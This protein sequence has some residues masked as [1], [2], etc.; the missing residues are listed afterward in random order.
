MTI[1]TVLLAFFMTWLI[2][3]LVVGNVMKLVT[4]ADKISRGDLDSEI[5]V[6]SKDEIGQLAQT[7]TRMQTA[8]RKSREDAEAIDWLKEG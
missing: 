7:I 4:V 8:L 6:E 1:A 3:R 2:S 5:N